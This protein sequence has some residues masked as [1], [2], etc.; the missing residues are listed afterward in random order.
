MLRLTN[1]NPMHLQLSPGGRSSHRYIYILNA[2]AVMLSLLC[3]AWSCITLRKCDDVLLWRQAPFGRRTPLPFG[4]CHS[5]AQYKGYR[6]DCAKTLDRLCTRQRRDDGFESHVYNSLPK[7]NCLGENAG[8]SAS[9]S[10]GES[11]ALSAFLAVSSRA[12]VSK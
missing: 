5:K 6:R 9:K 3:Q 1:F 12:S 11:Y 4:L 8:Q 7:G 2:Y 10:S